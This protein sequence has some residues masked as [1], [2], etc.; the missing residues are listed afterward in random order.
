MMFFV[1]IIRFVDL[2][3][4]NIVMLFFNSNNLSLC[5]TGK[6]HVSHTRVLSIN[7]I[8]CNKQIIAITNIPH[9]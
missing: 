8:F 6:D 3:H 9:F 1:Q 7:Y 2:L 4:C 5:Q